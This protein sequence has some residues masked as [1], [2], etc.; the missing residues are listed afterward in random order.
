MARLP[1]ADPNRTGPMIKLAYYFTRRGMTKMT[2]R[3]PE[4]MLEPLTM[5][6]HL[7]V[8]MK[9]YGQLEQAVAK[10]DGLDKR[11][12][13][14]AELKAATLTECEY[15][16]DL[17]SQVARRQGI[18]DAELLALPHYDSSPL[19]DHVD[20]LVLSYATAMSRTPVEVTDELVLALREHFDVP[21][22]VELTNI[23]ALEN[24]RGRFNLALGIGAAGFSDGLVCAL[25]Q[26]A[27]E[28]RPGRG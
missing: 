24:M 19:F 1:G 3:S 28:A 15:C 9:G 7:P 21:Q 16:I 27:G 8:L 12:R 22:V 5:Y 17:G 2:G 4:T 13:F 6:A 18:T 26:T 20:K 14:L 10:L 25:P 11:H 23:I